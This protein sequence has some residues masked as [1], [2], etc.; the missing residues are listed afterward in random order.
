M[1]PAPFNGDAFVAALEPPSFVYE[2]RTYVG[3]VLS[4]EQWM[5]AHTER[6]AIGESAEAARAFAARLVAAWF[7]RRWYHWRG[8][9]AWRAFARMPQLAQLAALRSFSE[10]QR[11]AITTLSPTPTT[12][13]TE[14]AA[15][16]RPSAT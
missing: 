2:G 8:H 11:R 12:E 14:T 13:A 15:P 16:P 5:A 9:P 3:R 1:P 4:V 10:A 7:P 6:D